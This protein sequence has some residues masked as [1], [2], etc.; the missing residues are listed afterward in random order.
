MK[1][2]LKVGVVAAGYIASFL[3]ATVAVAI[4]VAN[5][6]GPDAQAASGMYAFGDSALFV[7]VFGLA[8]LVP[9]A[10]ALW[11]LRPY[12]RF[13]AVLS[14]LALLVAITGVAAAILFVTGR[15]AVGP[16]TLATL[17]SFSVLRI[18]VSPLLALVFLVSGWLAPHR[19]PRL[20]FL[21]AAAMEVGVSAC[22]G[23]I[24]IF[25]R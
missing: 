15:H 13:W 18:L 22:G 24:W 25:S 6:S 1:P 11:L 2:I 23:V 16:S 8:A 10:G 4:R 5:T 12:R 9:T 17:A 20:G 21:A 14:G 3:V 7:A 19:T